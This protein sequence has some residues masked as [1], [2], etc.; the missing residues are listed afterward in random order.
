MYIY[1]QLISKDTCICINLLL[2]IIIIAQNY[3]LDI[4]Y[5]EVT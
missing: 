4:F 2:Y 1:I 3:K 5:S